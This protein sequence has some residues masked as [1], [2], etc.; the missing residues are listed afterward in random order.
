MFN[1]LKK[2]KYRV[3]AILWTKK[4]GDTGYT[5]TFK[6]LEDAQKAFDEVVTNHTYDGW[7]QEWS[8][9]HN[10]TIKSPKKGEFNTVELIT[11]S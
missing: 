6:N 1:F 5:N 7:K 3:R 8:G 2:D 11:Y 10:V 4:G 9:S